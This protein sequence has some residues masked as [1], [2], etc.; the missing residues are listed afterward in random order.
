[1][2]PS[3]RDFLHKTTLAVAGVALA[4]RTALAAAAPRVSESVALSPLPANWRSLREIDCHMHVGLGAHTR[5]P[6]KIVEAA[7]ALGIQTML[8]SLPIVGRMPAAG[9]VRLVNDRV[10]QAMRDHPGRF[11]G[12]CFLVPGLPGVL[13]EFDRCLAAGM[14][15][16][17]L[18]NQ[19]KFSHPVVFPIVE[20][21]IR[22]RV[23]LLGHAGRSYDA[24]SRPDQPNRSDADD[25][26]QLAS[27]YPEAML[28]H[29]HV[30]G[31]ADWEWT[32]KRLRDCPGVYLDTSGTGLDARTIDEAVQAL[33]HRRVLFGTDAVFEH[34]IGNV[35]SAQLTAE[36]REDVF[37]RNAQSILD[38]RAA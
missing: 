28:I 18:Y 32:I 20:K 36:Q 5:D 9:E 7:D 31:G 13:D 10:L 12:Y 15:G 21:C 17:K 30:H 24:R 23:P 27:R 25:F 26:C 1:M 29:A 22:H 14:I 19:F 34:G 8:T 6:Q 4:R 35:L 33:G 38:R 2:S 3:R 11:R 16:V 37:W